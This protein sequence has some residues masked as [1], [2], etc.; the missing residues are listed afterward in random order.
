MP[1][2]DFKSSG[3]PMHNDVI[4]HTILLKILCN[5]L[6]E[7]VVALKVNQ[8]RN[9]WAYKVILQDIG[10]RGHKGITY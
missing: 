1:I 5:E 3:R 2:D 10:N 7:F 4:V 9:S 6:R 8:I